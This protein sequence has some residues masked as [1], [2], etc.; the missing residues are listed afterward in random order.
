MFHVSSVHFKGGVLNFLHMSVL[1]LNH[2][3]TVH[4]LTVMHLTARRYF[5]IHAITF[6]ELVLKQVRT[7][8]SF[9]LLSLFPI[10]SFFALLISVIFQTPLELQEGLGNPF[11]QNK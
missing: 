5:Y 11:L 4:T 6:L 10:Q 9:F 3:V 2:P 8:A 7:S 1:C